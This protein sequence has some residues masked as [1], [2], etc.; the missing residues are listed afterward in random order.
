MGTSGSCQS[1]LLMEKNVLNLDEVADFY[2][3]HF[4][5]TT[6]PDIATK[7]GATH[8][9]CWIFLNGKGTVVYRAEGALDK[10][11][12]LELGRQ[13]LKKAEGDCF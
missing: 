13:V 9:P 3:R 1:C 11:E 6:M 5:N 7:Y 2:N 12:F 10:K 4:I 8:Y